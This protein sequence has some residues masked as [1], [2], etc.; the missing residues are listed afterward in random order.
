MTYDFDKPLSLRGKHVSKYDSISR[1]YGTDDPDV[2]PMWVADMDFP[3]APAILAALQAE[4]DLGYMGYF[5][6][7]ARADRAVANWYKTRH[8]WDVDPGCVRYTHG[9]V[10]GFGD[11]LATYSAPGDAVIVFSPVYHAFYRQIENMGRKVVESHLVQ[12]D[13]QFY[14]DLDALQAALTGREKVVTFCSPHNPG[15]RIWSVDEIKELAAF[16]AR[17]DLILLSDEI[18]MDLTFPGVSFV[19]TAVAAPECLDRLVVLTAASKGF[20]VAGAE[21]GLLLAPDAMVRAKVDKVIADRESSPNRF[22]M[23]IV[24]AAF[25]ESADWSDAVRAY[26]AENN[27]IF[28][29]RMSLIPG[30]SVMEMQSTYLSWVDFSALG[31]SDAELLKRHIDAK[32]APNPG[33]QFGT[34]GAGH[35]RFNLALPRA[36][37]LEAIDRIERAFGDLQ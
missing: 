33:T 14:M 21:T 15:G 25:E 35:M 3:A 31:M 30:V 9:V 7:N 29:E 2:I 23:A 11:V 32:V 5:G 28:T 4:I 26:L 24:C 36:T 17:N 10:S 19:P 18:H 8:G 6:D 20:N 37:M 27:R 16:C 1:V 22:G 12:R 13:G 34:G